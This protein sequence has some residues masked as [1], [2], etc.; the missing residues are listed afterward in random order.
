MSDDKKLF[1]DFINTLKKFEES[2]STP[3]NSDREKAGCIQFF[4]FCFELAWKTIKAYAE[5]EGLEAPSPKVALKAGFQLNLIKNETVWLDM[6]IAR[7]LMAHTYDE[8]KSLE[9]FNSLNCFLN[10]FNDF[11]SNYQSS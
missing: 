10:E 7:N 9:V 3:A 6:L 11:Q 5:K 2:L 8:S 4:E 1:Q